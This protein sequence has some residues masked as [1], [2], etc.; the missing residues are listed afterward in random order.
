MNLV[1]FLT[2]ICSFQLLATRRGVKKTQ[3][4]AEIQMSSTG[5]TDAI[6]GKYFNQARNPF[7]LARFES[8]EY[9]TLASTRNDRINY[10]ALASYQ[11][12]LIGNCQLVKLSY[13]FTCQIYTYFL[14]LEK[15][16]VFFCHT[17][18]RS[19]FLYYGR[20]MVQNVV[21]IEFMY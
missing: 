1:S 12:G 11:S 15:F 13:L 19:V 2:S 14:S 5:L 20:Q 9:L 4:Q 8:W 3:E 17:K 10:L 16:V 7:D 6:F 21:F 18:N